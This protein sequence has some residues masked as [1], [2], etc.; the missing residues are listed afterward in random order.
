MKAHLLLLAAAALF[1]SGNTAS[2]TAEK[3]LPPQKCLPPVPNPLPPPMPR[4]HWMPRKVEKSSPALKAVLHAKKAFEAMP[5]TAPALKFEAKKR[6]SKVKEASSSAVG[7]CPR[8]EQF[9]EDCNSCF[10]IPETGLTGCTQ[11]ACQTIYLEHPPV[12]I[13]TGPLLIDCVEDGRIC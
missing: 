12:E 6:S 8:G 3:C 10:C 5:S 1:V 2:T 4:P 9:N 7:L 13:V 11:M